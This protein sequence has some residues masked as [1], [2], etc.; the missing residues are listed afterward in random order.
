MRRNTL[1]LLALAAVLAACGGKYTTLTGELKYGKSAEENYQAGVDE[2]KDDHF[3]ESVKFFE[4]VKTKYPFS[5]YAALAELRLADLKFKQERYPEA[6]EDYQKFG[7][8]HPTHEEVD[9]AAFRVGLSRFKDAPSDF[10]MFPPSYE[11]DQRAVGLAASSFKDFLAKYPD[12]KYAPEARK[13]HAQV[14]GRLAS[15]EWYVAEFYFKRAHWAGAA[16]RLEGLVKDYPG[17]RHEVEAYMKLADAYERMNE[18]YRARTALQQFLAK[19][20]QDPRRAEAEKRL[21]ALR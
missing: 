21:A 10:W 18:K 7:Q 19:H 11:K 3:P 13:L 1:A 20:P 9:Y 17:S 5:R 2:L 6:A 16:A 15:H 14:Q 8:L 12:S 4:H